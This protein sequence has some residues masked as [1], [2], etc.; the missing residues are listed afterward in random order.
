MFFLRYLHRIY[1]DDPD[2]LAYAASWGMPVKAAEFS[3]EPGILDAVVLRLGPEGA[4]P[5]T[6]EVHRRDAFTGDAA[7]INVAFFW[8]DNGQVHRLTLHRETRTTVGDVAVLDMAPPS[9]MGDRP[10]PQAATASWLT[11][12]QWDGDLVT[13]SDTDCSEQVFP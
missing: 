2:V 13:F 8:F 10:S 7:P 9:I 3:Q 4:V 1:V 6:M 12:L 5:S 11:E